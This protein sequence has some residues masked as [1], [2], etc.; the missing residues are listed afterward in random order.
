MDTTL[1]SGLKNL[2][3]LTRFFIY[4]YVNI[5][6]YIRM[7]TCIQICIEKVLQNLQTILSIDIA[8]NY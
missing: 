8:N 6:E 5:Y 4:M 3:N 7:E 1:F 2:I